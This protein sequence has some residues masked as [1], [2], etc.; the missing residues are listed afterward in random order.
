MKRVGG[1]VRFAELVFDPGIAVLGSGFRQVDGGLERFD[2]AKE[3]PAVALGV[4]PVLE[5]PGRGFGDPRVAAFAPDGHPPTDLVDERAFLDP[6]PGPLR[7]L[8]IGFSI[9]TWAM[10]PWLVLAAAR[11]SA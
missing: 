4:G 9:T 2:L 8:R 10:L 5:Q 6:V 3:Q 1:L 7:V 11:E